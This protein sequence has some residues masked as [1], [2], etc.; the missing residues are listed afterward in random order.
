MRLRG[1]GEQF[2]AVGRRA[3]PQAVELA[4]RGDERVFGLNLRRELG[5]EQALAD[6]ERRDD[7]LPG[8]RDPN[9]LL[10]HRR[11]IGEQRAARR[12]DRFDRHQRVH[13]DPL[14]EPGEFERVTRSG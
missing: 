10:E 6:A 7:D 1:P 2:L 9:D 8:R 14:D 4:R 13:L 5:I 12:R 11:A 3:R